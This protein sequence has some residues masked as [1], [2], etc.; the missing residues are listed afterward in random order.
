MVVYS[1]TVCEAVL[2]KKLSVGSMWD[3]CR[4]DVRP[5]QGRRRVDVGSIWGPCWVD[6]VVDGKYI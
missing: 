1:F 5:M 4:V 6:V 2:K 3:R